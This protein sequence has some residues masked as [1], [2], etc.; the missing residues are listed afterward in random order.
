MK[1]V[2]PGDRVVYEHK[3]GGFNA[4]VVGG[5]GDQ[6]DGKITLIFVHPTDGPQTLEGVPNVQFAKEPKKVPKLVGPKGKKKLETVT[7]DRSVA[8]GFW[9]G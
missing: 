6:P 3:D 8:N 2:S 7:E 9:R 1:E 4:L 5:H